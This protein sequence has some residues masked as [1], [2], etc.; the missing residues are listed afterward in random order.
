MKV[1]LN[2]SFEADHVSVEGLHIDGWKDIRI[3]IIP[4]EK[5]GF[6]ILIDGV[7]RGNVHREGMSYIYADHAGKL[8]FKRVVLRPNHD[9]DDFTEYVELKGV[10]SSWVG[11]GKGKEQKTTDDTPLSIAPYIS[12]T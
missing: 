11:P 12:E 5:G 3:G 6:E 9:H 4:N 10:R 8:S 7:K 1:E 2:G